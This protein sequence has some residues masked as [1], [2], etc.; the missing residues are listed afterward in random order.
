M[1][2]Q[3]ELLRFFQQHADWA[4]AISLGLNVVVAIAGVLP[5]VFI[6]AANIYFF[7][8][9]PGM[10]ISI[11]GESV[12]AA[13]SFLLYR[14]WFRKHMQH[15]L[16]RFPKVEKLVEAKGSKAASLVFVLRLLPMVPSGIVTFAAAI[17]QIDFLLFVV[18]STVGKIPALLL[19]ACVV[20]GFMVASWPLQIGIS[21]VAIALAIWLHRKSKNDV[22]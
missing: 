11:A 8:F 13:I 7:G 10:A 22:V 18:T 20:K 17:G 5:S 6:T 16:Y 15:G 12:G 21:V 1:D 9:W 19:E 14:Y 2:L 4:I 3:A